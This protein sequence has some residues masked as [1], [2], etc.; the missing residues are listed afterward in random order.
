MDAKTE[1]KKMLE[2][3]RQKRGELPAFLDL[4]GEEFPEILVRHVKDKQFAMEYTELP[5]KYKILI[6]LGAAAVLGDEDVIESFIRSGKTHEVP[7][8]EMIHAIL[9]A[10]F[11]KSSSV[12]K[13]SAKGLALLE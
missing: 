4:L 11:V 12:L 6:C 7:N 1:A 2:R 13:N 5:D 10:R 3:M 9:L 8:D